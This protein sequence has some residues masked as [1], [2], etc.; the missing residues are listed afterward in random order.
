MNAQIAQ[1]AQAMVDVACPENASL[2]PELHK[3]SALEPWPVRRSY[4]VYIIL[5]EQN[6]VV[7]TVAEEVKSWLLRRRSKLSMCSYRLASALG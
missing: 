2:I 6:S 7:I 1:M 3:Q 5:E 4:G